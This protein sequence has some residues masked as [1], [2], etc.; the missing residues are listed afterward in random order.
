MGG[1]VYSY[2]FGIRL[3]VPNTFSALLKL[4]VF[5][6]RDQGGENYICEFRSESQT[7]FADQF[8]Q[9]LVNLCD[10]DQEHRQKRNRT[11]VNSPRIGEYRIFVNILRHS[12]M[13][14]CVIART[15]FHIRYSPI[16]VYS[17]NLEVPRM[18]AAHNDEY[19]DP[20]ITCPL[21]LIQRS[22][23]FSENKRKCSSG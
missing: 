5:S 22:R 18:Y 6:T 13:N 1:S 15:D 12:R 19:F 4:S 9:I 14:W 17:A 11:Y 3:H 20:H 10:N 23:L 21:V 2:V 16:F 7:W 8:S